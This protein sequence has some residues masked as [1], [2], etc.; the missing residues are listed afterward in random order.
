MQIQNNNALIYWLGTIHPIVK[1]LVNLN[2]NNTPSNHRE[3]DLVHTI[4]TLDTQLNQMSVITHDVLT[5]CLTFH[6]ERVNNQG[7]PIM[8]G[9]LA[10]HFGALRKDIH[11]L[12]MQ[13]NT[14]PQSTTHIHVPDTSWTTAIGQCTALTAELK[15]GIQSLKNHTPLPTTPHMI[16][17]DIERVV[18]RT[19]QSLLPQPE[20]PGDTDLNNPDF[21]A[22]IHNHHL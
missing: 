11:L 20:T 10:G 1:D 8:T 9:H 12:K 16:T 14:N 7:E 13:L 3:R 19:V 21:A 2:T 15:S 18:L 4:K 6:P 17:D 22:T 5:P